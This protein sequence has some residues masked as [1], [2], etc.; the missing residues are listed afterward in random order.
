MWMRLT[1]PPWPDFTNASRPEQN[2]PPMPIAI[3][4]C[5]AVSFMILLAATADPNTPVIPG[6]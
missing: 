6:A 4:V 1:M 5:S 3:V 2:E